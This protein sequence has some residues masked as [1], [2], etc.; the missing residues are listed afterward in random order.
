M[1]KSPSCYFGYQGPDRISVCRPLKVLVKVT[2]HII[3]YKFMKISETVGIDVS[4]LVVDARIQSNQC[5]SQ[6]ENS[7]KGF[8]RLYEWALKNS[9]FPLMKCCLFSNIPVCIHTTLQFI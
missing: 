1:Y 9:D 8:K 7:S 3:N 6:F 2:I 5:F 4:K